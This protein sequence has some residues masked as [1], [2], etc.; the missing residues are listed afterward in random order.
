MPHTSAKPKRYVA[1]EIGEEFADV[2]RPRLRDRRVDEARRVHVD[3][4]SIL[5]RFVG[6]VQ[7]EL[8][9]DLLLGVQKDVLLALLLA[10]LRALVVNDEAEVRCVALRLR[11]VGN[12]AA[13][14]VGDALSWLCAVACTP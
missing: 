6:V 3:E 13:I 9:D 7:V 10:S 4:G 11:D 1:S 12:A 2:E 8:L 14:L 5:P